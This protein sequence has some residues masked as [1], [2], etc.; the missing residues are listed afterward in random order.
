MTRASALRTWGERLYE[1]HARDIAALIGVEEIPEI[2][3][4]VER[5]GHGAAWTSGTDV[6]LS[7]RWFS[8]HP[9]DA[10]GVLHEFTHAIM[11][12]PTYDE[13][14]SW[15]IEGLAD[16]V[17]D[18]LGHDAPWTKAHH[19]P[20]KATAGYQT[21]AH[22][23]QHL[24]KKHPGTVKGLARALIEDTYTPDAFQQLTG[25]TLELCVSDYEAEASTA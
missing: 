25:K 15:L 9:D 23:L 8:E 20:G 16:W 21:T 24:E 2:T 11:R 13:T 3:V 5:R 1:R 19:E 12:A 10:G 4:H 17:R 14:T 22:F 18:E 6:F 7:P